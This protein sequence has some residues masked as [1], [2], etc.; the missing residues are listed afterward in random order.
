MIRLTFH[1]AAKTVT[2]SKYLLEAGGSSVLVDCGLFQGLKNL[3]DK[4]WQPT[5]FDLKTLDSVILTHAHLDHV[6]YLPRIVKEGYNHR[7][8]CT[9]AT[10]ELAE[11][12]LLDSAK[13]QESDAEYANKKGYSKH[14]PALPLYDGKDVLATVKLFRE[15]PREKW[16]QVAG[17]IWARFHD[18]GHLLGSNMIEVEIRDREPAFRI[19]FSG[20]VGRYDGPLYHD[21]TPPT[22]CDVLVCEST[23]GNRDHPEASLLDGL[24]DVLDRAFARGGVALMASF[25]VGR[26]QQ[27]IYLMEVLKC[28][29]RLP[30]VPIYLDSPMACNASDIYRDHALDHDLTEAELCGDRPMLDGPSVHLCRTVDESKAL[31]NVRGPAVII[32]SSG[33]MT[34][35]R[36]LHHLQ[37]RLPDKRNTVV[38]GGFMAVGTRGRSLEDGVPSL[39]MHGMDIPVRAAIEKVPGLSGHADR[40]ELLRWLSAIKQPPKQ[41]FLTH[42]EPDAASALAETLAAERGWKVTVPNL[43]E[44]HTLG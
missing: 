30:D 39:R 13:I 1:G 36:I 20:D 22:E 21:P 31:N 38:L 34:A 37:R 19:L 27:L 7:I 4:N 44:S 9:E 17:P 12:I 41:V 8:L 40:S 5:P 35:G 14:K 26:A 25:A 3:R 24:A 2:G 10:A 6:G 28:Q 11:I 29:G 43:G 23:Y 15:I 33:M 18:A 42:G 16:H 32:S